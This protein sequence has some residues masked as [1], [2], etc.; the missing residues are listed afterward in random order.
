MTVNWSRH[1]MVSETW[2]TTSSCARRTQLHGVGHRCGQNPVSAGKV[3][4]YQIVIWGQS[5]WLQYFGTVDHFYSTLNPVTE[6][7]ILRC[8][9][10][11]FQC[12]TLINV[13]LES[14]RSVTS[15]P[16]HCIENSMDIYGFNP[17][18]HQVHLN[19]VSN[20]SFLSHREHILLGKQLLFIVR[21]TEHTI[22]CIMFGENSEYLNDKARCI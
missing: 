14:Y 18:K 19:N 20:F 10:W 17:L 22:T 12:K 8:L 21:I 7:A 3:L 1:G 2:K 5:K 13:L 4:T 16:C 15:K 9:S 6:L 11:V